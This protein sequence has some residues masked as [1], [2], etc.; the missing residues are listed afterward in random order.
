VARIGDG[1]PLKLMIADGEVG[2]IPLTTAENTVRHAVLL[3]GSALLGA[4]G[5]IF[6]DLW[7]AATPFGTAAPELAQAPT[8]QDR[9]VLSLLASGATDET[10]GRVLGSS[11]RTAHRRVRELMG[12]LGV[13][14]RFQAGMQAVHLGWL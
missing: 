2:L 5:Q 14:T 3:R 7:R 9:L 6:D 8:E 11:P 4:L 12:R 1:L 10:I 13:R